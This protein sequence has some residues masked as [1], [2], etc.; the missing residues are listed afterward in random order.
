M[1]NDDDDKKKFPCKL[2]ARQHNRNV[3]YVSFA[4]HLVTQILNPFRIKDVYLYKHFHSDLL[5]Y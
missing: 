1:K 2:K 4:I 5:C 3:M